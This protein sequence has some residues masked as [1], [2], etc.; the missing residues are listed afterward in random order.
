MTTDA[1]SNVEVEKAFAEPS[2]SR[3]I[4]AHRG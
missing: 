2:V 4:A 1:E 3:R